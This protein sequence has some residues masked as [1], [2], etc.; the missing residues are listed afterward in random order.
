MGPQ[1][2]AGLAI[3]G[4]A[5]AALAALTWVAPASGQIDRDVDVAGLR[6]AL[7][8]GER[9]LAEVEAGW[10]ASL[11]PATQADRTWRELFGYAP[12]GRALQLAQLAA[13]LYATEGREEDALRAAHLLVR[14]AGYREQVPAELVGSRVEYA[15][16]LPAVPSFFH[17]ADYAEAW[18]RVRGC[19][20]IDAATRRT[21]DEALAGSADFVFVFPEWGAHNRA[22]LRAVGLAQ[23]ARTLPAHPRAETW[24]RMAAALAEDSLGGWEIEDAQ[25]YHPIWLFALLRYAEVAGRPEVFTSLQVR[26]Y[27][28]YFLE[29]LDPRGAVPDFG[30]GWW[31][32]SLARTY[33]CLEWGAARLADPELRWGARRVYGAMGPDPGD[34]SLARALL[35]ARLAG[36]MDPDLGSREPPLTSGPVLDDVIGKKLVLRDGRGPDDRYLLLNFRDEGDWGVLQRDYLRQTLAVEEEK[37]HHGHSDEGALVLFMQGGSVLL[38]DAGYRDVAPSGPHGAYRADLFH[39]RLVARPRARE[40]GQDLFEL[41]ADSGAYRPTRTELVDFVRFEEVTYARVRV[42]A[43]GAG[44]VWD[45]TLIL[46]HGPPWVVVVDTLR[47]TE[48]GPRTFAALWAV[49]ELLESGPGFALGATTRV[50]DREL[51]SARQL[52][53]LFPGRTAAPEAFPLV[54]HRRREQVLCAVQSGVY[55]PGARL[56]FATV[57]WPVDPGVDPRVLAD[58]VRLLVADPPGVAVALAI[59]DADDEDGGEARWTL[60][61][62]ADLTLGLTEADVRPRY[63]PRAGRVESDGLATDADL[64][65]VHRA[66]GVARWWATDM[67]HVRIDGR[68]AMQARPM[69][70]FQTSGRSDVVGRAKWR[71]WEGELPIDLPR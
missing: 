39:N 50:G 18:E 15:D 46:P 60:L 9:G 20:A 4:L 42:D 34:P 69:Q 27:L 14:M 58:R 36:R 47:V 53:L 61:L 35:F 70:F 32:G 38:H 68:V 6:R 52:A 59:D 57:L 21:V 25:V 51:P 19:R 44:Y 11:E 63:D 12:P 5:I 55:D 40:A 64:L 30:D 48:P 2:T 41:L 45:R 26:Y 56:S 23:T 13:F 3:R 49:G 10:R 22:M 16:G 71:R 43:L 17:L 62:K 37:M 54:R 33:A 7:E 66:G 31:D 1:P 8:R 29:L 67:T 24:R 65:V 28:R